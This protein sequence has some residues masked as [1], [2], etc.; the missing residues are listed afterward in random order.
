MM[1]PLLLVPAA[2]D[3]TID[4]YWH[5]PAHSCEGLASVLKNTTTHRC[6]AA[7]AGGGAASALAACCD[8]D[9]S[10]GG[11]TVPGGVPK[12]LGCSTTTTAVGAHCTKIVCA[13][14]ELCKAPGST[15][16][17]DC[18]GGNTCCGLGDPGGANGTADGLFVKSNVPQQGGA[19]PTAAQ[20]NWQAREVGAF[21]SWTIEEHCGP[22]GNGPNDFPN[23][24][25][26]TSGNCQA[27]QGANNGLKEC[28]DCPRPS[29][30]KIGEKGFTDTWAAS[31]RALGAKYAVMV[32]KQ[33]CG[34]A[35]WPSNVTLPSGERYGYSV[36]YSPTPDRDIAREFATSCRKFNITPGFY[37]YM[38][39]NAYLGVVGNKLVGTKPLI[40]TLEVYNKLC[41]AQLQ[42]LWSRY[43]DLAEVWFDGGFNKTIQ[44]NVTAL[45]SKLQPDGVVFNG[46]GDPIGPQNALRWIGSERGYAPYPNWMTT[47]R[48]AG[49][50][51]VTGAGDPDGLIYAPP[52]CDTTLQDPTSTWLYDP[53]HAKPRALSDLKLLYHQSVGRSCGLELNFAPMANGTLA[54]NFV[55]RLNEF[56]AWIQ[57][58]YGQD[59]SVPGTK[60]PVG[61]A[62]GSSLAGTSIKIGLSASADRMVLM[63]DLT[64][65]QRIRS[66][67]ISD[68]AGQ[69]I[70]N[71]SS[72]GHK[73]IALLNTSAAGS[74]TVA[75]SAAGGPAGAAPKLV[76]AAA[77]S[78]DDC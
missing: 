35:M 36:A 47:F 45:F 48:D 71:G 53:F 33:H 1:L 5:L 78:G 74:M 17:C 63:E 2:L 55:A 75:I 20:L 27:V 34:W 39:T 23:C 65:G 12:G 26:H 66:F 6:C 76:R 42:E 24:W 28:A 14:N 13:I 67:T 40:G 64:H 61:V 21:V 9:A 60:S 7:A 4:G 15:C 68:A 22:L 32:L 73:H 70:Y 69:S 3:A 59:A 49:V 16:G 18:G 41:L 19:Q 46:P 62:S 51:A 29:S 58:C 31:M 50:P 37:M 25:K 11:F 44:P 77:Y 8:A 56:G 52:V 10:C 30:F 38:D 43:G 54:P 72:L 57:G